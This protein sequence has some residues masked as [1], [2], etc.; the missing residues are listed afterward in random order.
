MSKEKD[1]QTA[2]AKLTEKMGT[3]IIK[4]FDGYIILAQN[5]RDYI[6]K[7]I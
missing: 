2:I 7:Q 5:E 1:I 6:S 4:H 3:P